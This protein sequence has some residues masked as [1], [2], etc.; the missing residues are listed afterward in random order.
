MDKVNTKMIVSACTE[1]TAGEHT[2][3]TAGHFD[4]HVH[5]ISHNNTWMPSV[6]ASAI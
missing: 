6:M 1:A 5:N 3:C 4:T 2:I